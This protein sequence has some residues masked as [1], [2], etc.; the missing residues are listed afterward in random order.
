MLADIN[1]M[2]LFST[3]DLSRMYVTGERRQR[4]LAGEL[5]DDSEVIA[6][7]DRAL[8]TVNDDDECL[9]DGF[10][11]TV[12]QA[13]WLLEQVA[14]GRFSVSHVIYLVV[15]HEAVLNR[16]QA[17]GRLDDTEKVIE[18]RF[19]EYEKLTEPVVAWLEKRGIPVLRI[20]GE[21]ATDVVHRD[22][23]SKLHLS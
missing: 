10:P 20:D 21:R 2:H 19:K 23:V 12:S 4:M 22:I 11:R 5:L 15:T 17:R 16:L 8:K 13:Q 1:G 14:A 9:L 6:M 3:G 7:L 18:A